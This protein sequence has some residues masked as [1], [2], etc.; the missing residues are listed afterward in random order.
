V[1]EYRFD[2]QVALVT[3][4]GA[5]LGRAHAFELARRGAKV[6][7]NDIAVTAEG[8]PLAEVTARELREEG[9]RAVAVHGNVGEEPQATRLVEQT[10]AEFGRIDILVNN[11][12]GSGIVQET[13]TE[14]FIEAL[15]VHLFGMFWTLRA[16]LR[17]MRAPDYGRIINT[18][19][20]LG[21]FGAP[22][23]TLY[24][25][26]KAGI[27]GLTRAASLDNHDRDI[28]VNA[29]APVA[30]T[31][32]SKAYFESH[33]ELD[34]RLLAPTFVSPVV[35]YLAHR[36]CE[37][38]GENAGCGRRAGR[39]AVHGRGSRL[40]QSDAG[41]RAGRRQPGASAGHCRVPHPRQLDR[42]V[43]AAAGVPRMS[44]KDQKT[45]TSDPERGRVS[46]PGRHCPPAQGDLRGSPA[47][48]TTGSRS[49]ST[50]PDMPPRRRQLAT[51]PEAT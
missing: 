28:R 12:G 43:Q 1:A 25:T 37:L 20:A 32:L 14:T 34:I 17:H 44:E 7:I 19:S 8:T 29:L 4:S 24:A 10:V 39:P 33:S 18:T 45:K 49:Y 36:S 13:A 51:A 46:R 22:G 47:P 9:L 21:I 30:A 27:V 40:C 3:G 23:S 5:G 42:A 48:P 2:D 16:A 26:A 31:G 35:A 11:A 41:R 50:R 6:V 15:T 38:N